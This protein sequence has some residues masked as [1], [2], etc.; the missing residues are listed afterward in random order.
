MSR[1]GAGVWSGAG[2]WGLA[3]TQ[4]SIE[5]HVPIVR[6]LRPGT[7]E[8]EAPR[9]PVLCADVA[10]CGHTQEDAAHWPEHVCTH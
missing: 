9:G 7:H 10:D 1:Q 3:G 4:A 6:W 5:P 2:A 8:E